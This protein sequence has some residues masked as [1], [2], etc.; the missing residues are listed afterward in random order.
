MDR[1]LAKKH[2]EQ[3]AK[4]ACSVVHLMLKSF[5]ELARRQPM[6]KQA[7][8]Q[9]QVDL[10]FLNKI[11]A[12]CLQANSHD[13]TVIHGLINEIIFSATQRCEAANA[14][15]L[16]DESTLDTISDVKLQ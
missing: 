5:Y 9:I 12:R 10:Y 1:F 6:S 7:I 3:K 4:G 2:R 15:C 13:W 11:L 8:M 14:D 16:L